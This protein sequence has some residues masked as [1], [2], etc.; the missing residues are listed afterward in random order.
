[1]S[2]IQIPIES[3]LEILR[4]IVTQQVTSL[5]QQETQKKHSLFLHAGQK[6]VKKVSVKEAE[7]TPKTPEKKFSIQLQSES[8][9]VEKIKSEVLKKQN[10]PLQETI[11]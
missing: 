1:M 5:N 10:W 2:V 4:L 8:I 7:N 9:R 6:R 3:D 11:F